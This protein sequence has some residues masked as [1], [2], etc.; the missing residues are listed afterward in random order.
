MRPTLWEVASVYVTT[1]YTVHVTCV[2]FFW[3]EVGHSLI[4][5]LGITEQRFLFQT[6][7]PGFQKTLFSDNISRF[8]LISKLCLL[9][10]FFSYHLSYFGWIENITCLGS[11]MCQSDSLWEYR[12]VPRSYAERC[13]IGAHELS[14]D[15]VG[16][17]WILADNI[18]M[19]FILNGPM[20]N[21]PVE[22]KG[23]FKILFTWHESPSMHYVC[24]PFRLRKGL[25]IIWLFLHYVYFIRKHFLKLRSVIAFFLLSSLLT[26]FSCFFCCVL[27]ACLPLPSL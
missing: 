9:R 26:H 25:E 3:N 22:S 4:K 5:Y 13:L 14:V 7:K 8:L 17:S 23:V 19:P 11:V 27:A 1:T 16:Y 21:I 6:H 24:I 18:H 12:C 10:R 15:S 2:R 20:I